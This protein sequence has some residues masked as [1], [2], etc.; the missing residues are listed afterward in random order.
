MCSSRT[1]AAPPG[2]TVSGNLPDAPVYAVALDGGKLLVGAEVGTFVSGGNHRHWTKLGRNLPNVTVWDLAVS[3][4]G[5]TVVA[6]THG[7]GQW[8]IAIH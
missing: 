7:R 2:A 5:K 1:T 3:K 4:D 6:G 8:T